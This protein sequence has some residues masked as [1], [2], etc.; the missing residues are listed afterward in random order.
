MSLWVGVNYHPHDWCIDRI[1]V[2]IQMMV[3]AGITR[4][5]LGHLCWDSYEPEDGRYSFSWF[6]QVMDLF[7][8][9]KIGVILDLSTHPAPLWVHK[10]CPGCNIVSIA[11]KEQAPVHRYMEDVADPEYQKYAYRFAT[12]LILRYKDH[13]ALVA[14]G[15]CNELGDGYLSYSEYSRQRFIFWLQKKYCNIDALNKAWNTQR[16]SRRVEDFREIQF[17]ES[18]MGHGSPEAWLD[19]R[20][21]FGDGISEH[22]VNL[23]HL[24]EKYA[25]N[26]PYSSNHWAERPGV[27]F[28]Y[29][30]VSDVIAKYAAGLGFYPIL[31]TNNRQSILGCLVNL[32]YRLAETG[33]PMWF[34]EFITGGYGQYEGPR[35]LL[36]MYAMLGLIYRAQMV[37]GWTWRSMLGGEEQYL[38]GLLDH[39][40]QPS[41]KYFEFKEIAADFAKL[42]RYDLPYLPNPEVGIACSHDS[43]LVMEY[44]PRHYQTPYVQQ[45]SNAL[46]AFYDRNIDVNFIDLRDVKKNYRLI[47]VP[48]HAMIDRKTAEY[49]RKYV[50]NGGILVMTGYSAMV[51]ETNTVFEETHPGMLSDVFGIRI[52]GYHRYQGEELT[53]YGNNLLFTASDIHY[54]EEIELHAANCAFS[55]SVNSSEIRNQN[56]M[57]NISKTDKVMSVGASGPFMNN[58]TSSRESA[59]PT[60]PFSDVAEADG[61]KHCMISVH[62]FGMGKAYYIAAESNAKLLGE[63]YD[64]IYEQEQLPKPERI[65]EGLICRKIGKDQFLAVNTTSETVSF[66]LDGRKYGVL[67]ELE[68]NHEGTLPALDTELFI[69]R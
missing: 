41:R 55:Y 26:T 4:V 45:L 38:Y 5:R 27:G 64:Y 39:D 35:G 60:Q 18:E 62:N 47:I 69:S 53:I 67:H 59:E 12:K 43:M 46:E 54:V 23:C 66:T 36:R 14:F 58:L 28:D 31:S 44:A 56:D 16:W 37:I 2:D 1:A 17:P 51:D 13:P 22:M 49:L 7:A 9:A 24:V 6:D 10:K 61:E 11:G 52:G 57:E 42:E 30:K 48:G 29:L 65:R 8:K 34:L 25:A 32:H 21:F 3:N 68:Y 15:I 40:G 33:N 63:F 19:M 50:K 20:R